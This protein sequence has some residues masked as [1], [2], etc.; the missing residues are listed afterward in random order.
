MTLQVLLTLHK[1]LQPKATFILLHFGGG[2]ILI[3]LFS[4]LIRNVM[5][6]GL[7]VKY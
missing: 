2:K 1:C 7:N 4:T 3:L 5:D 6:I